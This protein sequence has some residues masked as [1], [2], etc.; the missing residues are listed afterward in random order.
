MNFILTLIYL[1]SR[2]TIQSV[3]LHF[4]VALPGANLLGSSLLTPANGIFLRCSNQTLAS[5]P[6]C[7]ASLPVSLCFLYK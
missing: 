4:V 1:L 5:C 2:D 3:R 6:F 7:F